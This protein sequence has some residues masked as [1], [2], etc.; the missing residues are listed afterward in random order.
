M[1]TKSA[2]NWDEPEGCASPRGWCYIDGLS[3]TYDGQK[4]VGYYLQ[5]DGVRGLRRKEIFA[6]SYLY[7]YNNSGTIAESHKYFP[8]IER[9]KRW[10]ERNAVKL[11]KAVQ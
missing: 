3:I 7:A 6:K 1:N 10:I 11:G 2:V 4:P 5:Y 8:T 9:A